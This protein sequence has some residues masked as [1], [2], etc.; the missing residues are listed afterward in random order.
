MTTLSARVARQLDIQI[1]PW[2]QQ[3]I[4]NFPDV[5]VSISFAD[6]TPTVWKPRTVQRQRS[7]YG[8]Y[9]ANGLVREGCGSKPTDVWCMDCQEVADHALHHS[10]RVA[11]TF[12]RV[13]KRHEM[14]KPRLDRRL[15]RMRSAYRARRR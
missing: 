1:E 7:S 4:D 15:S 5:S 3:I 14:R 10:L 13:F 8:A 12:T 9:L 11:E 2:Q 6:Q